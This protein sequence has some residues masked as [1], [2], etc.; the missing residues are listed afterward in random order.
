[1][2]LDILWTDEAKETF[3]IILNF[4]ANKWGETS[5]QKFVQKAHH[6]IHIMSQQPHLFKVANAPGIR[7]AVITGQTSLF[8]QV[9]HNH[10]VL[11]YFWDNRQEPFYT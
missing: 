11:M 1:M 6:T 9:N 4:I 10:I 8:Y 2:S 3:D 7:Q 5:A